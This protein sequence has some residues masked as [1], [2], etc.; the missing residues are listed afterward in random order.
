MHDF[1]LRHSL[2]RWEDAFGSLALVRG[3]RILDL[4]CGA[5]RGG[6]EHDGLR[7]TWAPWLCRAV[8]ELGGEAVGIDVGM[9][10]LNTSGETYG[11]REALAT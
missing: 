10:S 7:E 6:K 9:L 8:L 3:K 2:E 5:V 4:G 11:I 1:A